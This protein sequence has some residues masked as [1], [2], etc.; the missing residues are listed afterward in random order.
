MM[1]KTLNLKSRVPEG[2]YKATT[3]ND[4]LIFDRKEIIDLIKKGYLFSSEVM[5][6][7]GFVKH[8]REI[9]TS[10]SIVEHEKDERTYE[11]DTADIKAI[12]RSISTLDNGSNEAIVEDDENKD[13][14]E[15]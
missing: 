13:E 15:E 2:K 3:I 5:E 11:K 12:I 6:K 7:A 9:K 1:G 8:V 14:Y 4:K 10:I